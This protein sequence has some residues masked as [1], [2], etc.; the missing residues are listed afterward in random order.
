MDNFSTTSKKKEE[1][2]VVSQYFLDLLPEKDFD[3]IT[4][5]AS[6]ICK[7]PI[8]VI[9]VR[10]ED[11]IHIKSQVGL[12]RLS[13][14]NEVDIFCDYTTH[15]DGNFLLIN[16]LQN[17]SRFKDSPWV[18]R[19][20]LTFFAGICIL[21]PEGDILGTLG[22]YDTKKRSFTRSQREAFSALAFQASRLFKVR[23]YNR[24]L[25]LIQEQLL[26]K[27][28]ALR[29]FAGIVAHDMKM[30]LSNMILTSD[31]LRAKYGD[32]IDKKGKEYL[33]YL[34][35]SSLTLS[36]Y[37]SGLLAHYESDKTASTELEEF[38]I[39][40]LMEEIVE[41]LN[42]NTDVEINLPEDNILLKANKPALEQIFINLL[43]NS[44]KYGD[45]EHLIIDLDCFETDSHYHFKISDNGPGIHPSDLNNIFNLFATTKNLDR[46]G[47][48][49]N[50]IGL[51]TVKQLVTKLG[52]TIRVSSE[53]GLGTTFSFSVEKR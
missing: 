17:D 51:S 48:K 8:A 46:F 13:L 30:P 33:E 23:K 11:K 29:N 49:G 25:L 28:E 20:G 7:S 27:N 44:L 47:K 1:I 41:L 34:K 15:H 50:G 36:D 6:N 10:D 53:V 14:K 52:G 37:I 32:L 31:I 12:D 19:N 18:K 43:T 39:K 21:N 35:Q 3:H 16:D 26:E 22:V 4:F 42:I 24:S 40:D 2:N 5:L 38:G 45:K 9:T